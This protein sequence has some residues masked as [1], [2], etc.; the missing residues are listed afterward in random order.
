MRKHKGFSLVELII[1]TIVVGVV[2]SMAMAPV[3]GDLPEH[4]VKNDIITVEQALKI[5]KSEAAKTSDTVTADFALAASNNGEHGGLIQ[6]KASDGVVLT[7]FS[8]N[9]SVLYNSGASTIANNQVRFDY[10]GQPIDSLGDVSGFTT[11]ANTIAISFHDKHGI[12]AT[13]TLKVQPLTG[14]IKID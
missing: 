7:S 6:I 8:L 2:A 10:R 9:K 12:A 13:E 4:K 14:N 5:A 1:A 3:F 11:A